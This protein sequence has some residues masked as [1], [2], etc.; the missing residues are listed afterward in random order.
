MMLLIAVLL[1]TASIVALSTSLGLVTLPDKT[2]RARL[3][4]LQGSV[5][6]TNRR[7]RQIDAPERASR[8]VV[9]SGMLTRIRRNLVL[10]GHPAGWTIRNIVLAKVLI[11]A[12][13]MVFA[14]Q[15]LLFTGRPL[16]ALLGIIAIVVGYFVP[17]LLISSRATERQEEMQR[18]LPDVLDKI[19]IA[20]EAGLGFESAMA[21][22]AEASD[23]PLA[24]ELVR[25][26]QDMRLGMA[27]RSAY[28]ALQQRTSSEDIISFIRG[29]MQAEEHG[30]SMSSMVRI[31]AKEMRIKRRLRAE[32][33]AGRVSV[34]LLAPLMLCIFPVLF[35][36]VLGPAVVNIAN[37]F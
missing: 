37:T 32:A 33:K 34:Q 8:Y 13:M 11:P 29:V 28:Q 6:S 18:A 30:S 7:M 31:Q 24:E 36:V 26:V 21:H 9:T 22:T 3:Q 14:S 10:A 23:G 12:A 2:V 20:I 27:R 15:F 1:L 17:D 16:M 25:T 19:V 35:V 5:A 4:S